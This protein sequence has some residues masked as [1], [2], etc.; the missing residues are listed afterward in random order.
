MHVIA[1]IDTPI[2]VIIGPFLQFAFTIGKNGH[3]IVQRDR[4][5]CSPTNLFCCCNLE[6]LLDRL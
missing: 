4:V 2:R 1:D 3:S 6:S 5:E